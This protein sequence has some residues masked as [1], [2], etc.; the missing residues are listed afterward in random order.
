MKED[1]PEFWVRVTEMQDDE[2]VTVR[3]QVSPFD[4]LHI[5]D[6]EEDEGE[7]DGDGDGGGDGDD[8]F[9]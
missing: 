4:L 6:G 1:I 8:D 5:S 2:D 7:D 3:R 9:F